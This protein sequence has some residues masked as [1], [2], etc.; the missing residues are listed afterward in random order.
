[1][2][3]YMGQKAFLQKAKEIHGDFYD[4]SRV[5]YKG[6]RNPVTIGCPKHGWFEQT[7]FNHLQGRGCSTCG[8]EKTHIPMTTEEWIR[9]ARKKHGDYYDYSKAEYKGPFEKLTIICPKHGEF[10]QRASDHLS[11][12][13]CKECGKAKVRQKNSLG[14]EKFI[15]MAKEVHGEKYTYDHVEYVNNK[16][17]V[18]VTCSIHGDFPVWPF[19]HIYAHSGCPKCNASHMENE[20]ETRL[21]DNNIEYI[22]Q[23]GKKLFDWLG[24]QRLDFYLP[25]YKMAIECQGEQHFKSVEHFGGDE[26]FKKRLEEDKT[27]LELC[28]EHGI[29]VLYYSNCQGVEFPYKV[30][31]NINLLIEEIN[32]HGKKA[33]IE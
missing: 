9:K 33:D 1:M 23:C 17:Y 31:N 14:K 18:L 5:E 25:E 2:A 4:Y 29:D 21:K 13:G 11:G 8:V 10:E 3:R 22:A 7:P 24:Y 28:K 20:V 19:N 6:S 26:R 30:I 32:N 27:K 15:Q 12:Y 16:T